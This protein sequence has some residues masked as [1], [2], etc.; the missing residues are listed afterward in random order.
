V[1][2]ITEVSVPDPRG[3]EISLTHNS[4]NLGQDK[5]SSKMGDYQK[6]TFW[7]RLAQSALQRLAADNLLQQSGARGFAAVVKKQAG[8]F[9]RTKKKK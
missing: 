7:F 3:S 9:F 2:S 4:L 5:S 6:N 1:S 8:V